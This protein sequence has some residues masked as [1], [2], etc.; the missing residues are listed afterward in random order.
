MA[1]EKQGINKDSHEFLARKLTQ[2][3]CAAARKMSDKELLEAYLKNVF[4][5]SK[6]LSN[7]YFVKAERERREKS[8]A[9]D[10][11]KERRLLIIIYKISSMAKDLEDLGTGATIEELRMRILEVKRDAASAGASNAKTKEPNFK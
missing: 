2:A 10:Q 4:G 11:N 9:E 6:Y 7:T 8:L 3:H 5:L 1:I